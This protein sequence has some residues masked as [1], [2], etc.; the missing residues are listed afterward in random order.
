MLTVNIYSFRRDGKKIYQS[1]HCLK[2]SGS[3]IKSQNLFLFEG[4]LTHFIKIIFL[5]TSST[6]KYILYFQLPSLPEHCK[7]IFSKNILQA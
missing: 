6:G 5:V 3:G 4:N 1:H 7:I 2:Q